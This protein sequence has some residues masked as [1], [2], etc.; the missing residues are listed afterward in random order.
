[1][2]GD[3]LITR[4]ISAIANVVLDPPSEM[5]DPD[6]PELKVMKLKDTDAINRKYFTWKTPGGPQSWWDLDVC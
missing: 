1:M 4:N 6:D 3:Y 5:L 2:I